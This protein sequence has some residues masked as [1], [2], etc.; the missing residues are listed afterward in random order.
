[1]T[2]WKERKMTI[3]LGTI[4]AALVFAFTFREDIPETFHEVTGHALEE[5]VELIAGS[6]E[7][8]QQDLSCI[9]VQNNL[10][11]LREELAKL[12]ESIKHHGDDGYNEDRKEQVKREIDLWEK[13]LNQL[14]LD[15]FC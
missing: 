5:R 14:R 11:R 12:N 6:L 3:S 4:A 8:T 9:I 15:K 1:M 2:N 10:S 13:K 7:K